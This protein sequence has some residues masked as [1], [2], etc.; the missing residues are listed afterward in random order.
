M[1]ATAT[2]GDVLTRVGA[3]DPSAVRPLHPRVRDREDLSVLRCEASGV[4]FL[5]SAEH[6]SLAHYEDKVPD[7]SI[8]DGTTVPRPVPLSDDLRRSEEIRDLVAGRRWLDVGTGEGVLLDLLADVAGAAAGVEPNEVYRRAI[9]ARG[10]EVHWPLSDAAG[11]PFEVVTLFHVLEHLVEP[12]D[13]L[14][15][16]RSVMAPGGIIHVEVPHARDLLLTEAATEPFQDFTFWSEHLV[17][18]TR[19]SLAKV[20]AAGGFSDVEVFGLQRYPVA[21]HLH[22]LAAGR[23]GGHVAWAELDSPALRTAYAEVLD[24]LDRTDTLVA[25]ARPAA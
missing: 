11:E 5:S 10:H 24:R 20:L 7:E 15:E 2:P 19:E 4:I 23:P 9:A 25:R 18:H 13:T 16:I 1:T 14:A 21:N 17:L 12:V 8:V 22:W 3:I 6:M